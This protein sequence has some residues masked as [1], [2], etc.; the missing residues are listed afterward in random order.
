MNTPWGRGRVTETLPNGIKRVD[1]PGHG[2]YFVPAE[3]REKMPAPYRTDPWSGNGWFEEDCGWAM[4]AASFPEHFDEKSLADADR[5]LRNWFPSQWEEVNG[6]EL[7]P[8][9][10]MKRDEERFFA[11]HAND[12]LSVCA[13]GDWHK[14]VPEG[15]V[16]VVCVRGGRDLKTGSYE[17][18]ESRGFLVPEA[19]YV[20]KPG[21][22]AFIADP[23]RYA[24]WDEEP[25][26]KA[27]S[28]C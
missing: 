16:G 27:V 3:L 13:Y 26:T 5:T 6:R 4:V 21:D 23:E 18:R 12:F 8:G 7:Q 15:M 24:A 25:S 22:F 17:G 1:T 28:L 9:E 2:G 10:S 11:N 20:K 14:R 19:E